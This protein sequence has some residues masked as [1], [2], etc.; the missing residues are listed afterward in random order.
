MPKKIFLLCLFLIF[1][2]SAFSNPYYD[3]GEKYL[4]NYQYSSAIEQFRNSLRQYPTDYNSRIGLI[5]AYSA[6][7]A[8]YNN[9]A[10]DYQK[11]LND[12]RSAL[13]YIKYYDNGSINASLQ[14][15]QVKFENNIKELLNIL[16]PNT[17]PDGLLLSAKT[18]RGQSELPSSFI[19]YQQLLNT[20]YDKEATVASGDILRILKNPS[21]AIV[22]Y[23]K[24]LKTEPDNYELLIKIGEC[25]QESGN[26]K[27][28]VESFNKAMQISQNSDYAISN[29]E[30][31]WRQQIYKNPADAEAH[32][33][34][35][36]IYQH[37]GDFE[38]A[39]QEY[40]KASKLNPNNSTT[41]LNLGTLYQE[42]K[43]YEDAITQYDA[44]LF[45]DAKNINARKYKA[46]CL[47]ALDRNKE[48]LVE[49]K[50]ILALS[51]DD[52]EA[53]SAILRLATVSGNTEEFNAVVN[54]NF[55]TN[56][57]RAKAYY[58]YA[59][60]LH[61]NKKYEEAKNYYLKSLELNPELADAYLNL[62]DIYLQLNDENN[63]VKI[64]TE[65]RQIFPMNMDISKRLKEIQL[66]GTQKLLEQGGQALLAGQYEKALNLYN[67]IKPQTVDS[68]IGI[69]S[70]YQSMGKIDE[71]IEYYKKASIL[72][73]NNAEIFY[74]IASAYSSKDDLANAKIYLNK[75]LAINSNH[76]NAKNL[77]TYI[78]EQDIQ[79][80]L[81]KALDLYNSQKYQ[82]AYAMLTN[83]INQKPTEYITYYY[84]G[85]VLD[86]QNKYEQAITDYK[87]AIKY[88][89]QF[90][91][92]Y[93][94]I[95][96]DYDTLKNFKEAYNYYKKYLSISKEN[97][98]YTEFAKKRIEELKKNVPN[99]AQTK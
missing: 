35:G 77:L 31:I 52:S 83:M 98:E 72:S 51:P 23:D 76:Q 24:A 65:A 46:Q 55:Q 87:N 2:N 7:A 48:A 85:L 5:N 19:V 40:Q 54:Q 15:A 49:Y 1:A 60:D 56:S 6:R 89:S 11:A 17:T 88:D 8:Y 59:Y 29:L 4:N 99:L 97:N 42:Q 13:F 73:P 36:V 16:K 53:S 37:K 47:Q 14:N 90:D 33:N 66:A 41:K 86:E 79:K 9:T 81:D 10:K 57:D 50:R 95:G 64:L 63:A 12:S 21:R 67:S 69:A 96:V 44:V 75:V 94:S 27:A 78:S 61:K 68:I 43:K 80:N 34:L 62:S 3:L 32:A 84:R 91:L 38:A 93:Y 39:M 58:Q 30:K 70:T 45:T 74:Y 26:S 25:Y 22:Y 92:A 20:K 82:E 18:L 71:A 28:A